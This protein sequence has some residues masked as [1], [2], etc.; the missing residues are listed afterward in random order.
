[1]ILC[2]TLKGAQRLVISLKKYK[3]AIEKKAYTRG[4]NE[5]GFNQ[6]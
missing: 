2:P 3:R 5:V 6:R 4:A 1:M